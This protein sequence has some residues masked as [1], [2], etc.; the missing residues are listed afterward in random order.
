VLVS[1]LSHASPPL[2]VGAIGL[3]WSREGGFEGSLELLV[4][5]LVEGVILR[6]ARRCS[7]SLS[8]VDI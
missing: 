3:L 6:D 8:R 1:A 7:L 4:T 2:E 5:L